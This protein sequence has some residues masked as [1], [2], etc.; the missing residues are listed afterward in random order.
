MVGILDHVKVLEY[1]HTVAGAFCAKQL[2]ALGAE[3]IK[4]ERPLIGDPAR[5]IGPF[6]SD[7]PHPEKS[8]LFLYANTDK[9]GIT[10]DPTLPT[11]RKIFAELSQGSDIIIEDNS[12]QFMK[13]HALHYEELK[14]LKP[15]IIVISITPFGQTGP[16]S[17][18]KAF[19]FNVYHGSGLGYITPEGYDN[20]DRPPLKQGKY[21]SEYHSGI[22]AALITLGVLFG[23]DGGDHGCHIDFSMQEWE[24][25]LLKPK[26]EMF[27]Y[28]GFT[29]S[30]KTVVRQGH[31]MTRCKDGYVIIMLLEE[32]QWLRFVEWVNKTELLIDDRFIDPYKRAENGQALNEIITDWAKDRT[33]QEIYHGGQQK[34]VP[35]SMVS[36]P[37]DL[38]SSQQLKERG[39]LVDLAHPVAGSYSYPGMPYKLSGVTSMIHSPA[40]T[41]GQHN[42][43]I[44][45]GRLGYT[46]EDLVA[47]YRTGVI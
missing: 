20:L 5:K 23:V 4:V 42:E 36:K 3:V 40:P 46:T 18:Y 47:L 14:K 35:V 28:E 11:G 7:I 9:L 43:K 2:S 24:M 22:G 1:C 31:G 8:G 6:P 27:T 25:N 21:V 32:H 37:S 13:E 39:F 38:F 34:G 30:R 16:Y 33:M 29:P 12:H 15:N 10:L 44:Y 19:S 41:L 45:C 26:W 17:E